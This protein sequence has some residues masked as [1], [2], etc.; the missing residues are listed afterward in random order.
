MELRHLR[1]FTAVGTELHFG[2]AAEQL[3]MAQ[4]ALTKVIQQLEGE[5]GT[6]LLTRSTRRVELTEV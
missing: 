1:A 3:K 2:R 4:P 6:P 5:I